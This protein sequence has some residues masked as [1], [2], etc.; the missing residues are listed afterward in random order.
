MVAPCRTALRG[1]GAGEASPLRRAQE[2]LAEQEKVAQ[3]QAALTDRELD[4]QVRKPADAAR[5]QAGQEAE[6]RRV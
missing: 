5:C 1:G 4:T 3:C 2:V 6:A